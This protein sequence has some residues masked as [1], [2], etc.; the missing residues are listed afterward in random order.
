MTASSSPKPEALRRLEHFEI[1]ADLIAEIAGRRNGHGPKLSWLD[2][3][4]RGP[5][6][7]HLVAA[8]I[9]RLAPPPG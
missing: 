6:A 3:L 8:G 7:R 1:P 9:A 2:R 5:T 4:G